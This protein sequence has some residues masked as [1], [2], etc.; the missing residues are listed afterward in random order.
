[1]VLPIAASGRV[2]SVT[3]WTCSRTAACE[4]GPMCCARAGCDANATAT[5]VAYAETTGPP[6][7]VPSGAEPPLGSTEERNGGE[8]NAPVVRVRHAL[9]AFGGPAGG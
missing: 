9:P 4:S 7:T 6:L 2:E 3:C 8:G 1:M 5:S